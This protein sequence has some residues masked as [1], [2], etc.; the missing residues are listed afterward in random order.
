M[1][2]KG[3]RGLTLPVPRKW[4]ETIARQK[5][6]RFKRHH[7]TGV[8]KSP[9]HHPCSSFCPTWARLPAAKP[10]PSSFLGRRSRG[11]Q[12]MMCYLPN[13]SHSAPSLVQHA[14]QLH[15]PTDCARRYVSCASS[16]PT[17]ACFHSLLW[18]PP[19]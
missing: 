2:W 17:L 11:C 3:E 9:P 5:R 15:A 13:R 6:D 19:L 14:L 7:N 10:L 8:A 1:F 16:L 4:F 12:S 18:A